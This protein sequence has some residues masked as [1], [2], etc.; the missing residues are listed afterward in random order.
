MSVPYEKYSADPSC[1]L[2]ILQKA[3]AELLLLLLLLG[4]R[5]Y[6][7]APPLVIQ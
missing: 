3:Q 2:V 1:C 4:L 7:F 6:L 5:A